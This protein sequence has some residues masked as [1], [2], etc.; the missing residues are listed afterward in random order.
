MTTIANQTGLDRART[1][2]EYEFGAIDADARV[3]YVHAPGRSEIAGNHTDHEGGHVI[4][5]A[6]DVSVDGIAVANGTNEIRI[7]DD[8]FPTFSISLDSLA[9]RED[10][11]GTSEALV[12]GMA[13]EIASVGGTALTLP[14]PARCRPAA[15]CPAPRPWRPPTAAP[16]RPFG[17]PTRSTR[18]RSPR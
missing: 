12:R 4:A 17:A 9:V 8:G 10:E 13:H 7:A 3:L 6:L 15:A 16:W 18:S 5:G 11:L 1:L 2:F 14:L